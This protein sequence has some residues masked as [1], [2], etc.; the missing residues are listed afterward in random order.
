M[1]KIVALHLFVAVF[2]YVSVVALLRKRLYAR[3]EALLTSII[4]VAIR[5]T[6]AVFQLTKAMKHK[7]MCIKHTMR[8]VK[9]H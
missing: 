7:I 9:T 5:L 2:V 4:Y 6:V 1:F 3:T 8:T